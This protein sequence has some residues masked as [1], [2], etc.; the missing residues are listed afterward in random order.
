MYLPREVYKRRAILLG[1]REGWE[2]GR[3]GGRVVR[4]SCTGRFIIF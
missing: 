4:E 1:E 3:G 2:G